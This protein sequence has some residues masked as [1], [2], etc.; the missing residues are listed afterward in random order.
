MP[1][2]FDV[3]SYFTRRQSDLRYVRAPLT[4]ETIAGVLAGSG[5]LPGSA[6]VPHTI[7][8][9]EIANEAIELQHMLGNI[10]P[11]KILAAP[12]L[13]ELPYAL[14]PEGATVYVVSEGKLY[15]NRGGAWE[16]AVRAPDLSGVLNPEQLEGAIQSTAAFAASLRPLEIVAALPTIT[17]TGGVYNYNPGAIVFLTATSK[18]YALDAGR[19]WKP[20]ITAPALDGILPLDQLDTSI[21]STASFAQT[22]RSVTV[23]GGVSLPDLA[24][25]QNQT[26]YPPGTTVFWSTDQKTYKSVTSGDSL[27]W[28]HLVS[29][30]ELFGKVVAGQ[31]EAGA[32]GVDQ[33]AANAVI[34]EKIASDA[35]VARTIKAGEIAT[36]HMAANT[37]NGDRITAGTLDAS[38]IVADSITAG[39]IQ[40]GAITADELAT[41]S[42]IAVKIA[43]DA[44]IARHV[45]AGE[46]A[47]GHMAANSIDGDRIKANTLDAGK[48]IAGSITSGIIQAGAITTDKLIVGS[49]DNLCEDGGFARPLA[50]GSWVTDG[51]GL[52]VHNDPAWVRSGL[53]C[54]VKW[55]GAGWPAAA[56]S[57]IRNRMVFDVKEGDKLYCETWIRR[58][59]GDGGAS[60]FVEYFQ[61]RACTQYVSTS[62][63][64]S[65]NPAGTDWN[66]RFFTGTVSPAPALARWARPGL[67]ISGH[68]INNT[69]WAFDDVYFRK[70]IGAAYISDLSASAIKTGTLD[71][72][73]LTVQNLT[74]NAIN[75][76]TLNCDNLT[77]TNINGTSVK[78]GTIG[79]TQ[80]GNFSADKITTGTLNASLVSVT[81]L[82]ASNIT[83]GSINASIIG[84][85]N[86]N[87]SNITAGSLSA[88]RITTGT[89][90]ASLVAVTNLNAS[91]ITTGSLS[92]D[93]ITTG[94]LNASLVTV[95]NLNAS[96]ITAGTL[97]ASRID[98]SSLQVQNLGGWQGGNINVGS[99]GI[100]F[101]NGVN[102]IMGV[103]SGGILLLGG[104]GTPGGTSITTAGIFT[105]GGIGSAGFNPVVGGIQYNGQSFN[106]GF[107]GGF[108]TLNGIAVNSLVFKGGVFVG[109]T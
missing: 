71:C 29:T 64:F 55:I 88:D 7:T 40:T 45:K 16:G 59:G 32:I 2:V 105:T 52:T 109:S 84:V 81:N 42:V 21:V 34:A 107:S 60:A 78:P 75:T 23:V 8:A 90:N 99:S 47:T 79:T 66:Y 36:A 95:T 74:A 6:L 77:V 12:P 53:Y 30:A 87:A 73:L 62:F 11:V 54:A 4:A 98:V 70:M 96:N 101:S 33:L 83:T 48:I 25:P 17:Q 26:K 18:M 20:I 94:T 28:Q 15:I 24:L 37:I 50:D 44:I 63:F 3:T 76:G 57:A 43:S 13:P 92:A 56:D 91:N 41:N 89:L 100:T 80:L 103:A 22:L 102:S 38:K 10:R 82:N 104:S 1:G 58:N 97:S 49:F 51:G 14:Y 69:G 35:V 65:A 72:S 61:D 9:Q 85:T 31:I 106:L 39:Q 108:L 86:L 67:L 46:I 93:R 27:V 5:V 19:N 68:T